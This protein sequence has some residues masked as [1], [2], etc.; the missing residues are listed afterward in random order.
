MKRFVSLWLT[1]W[2]LDRLRRT[3]LA[4]QNQPIC[5]A[6][7]K[8][9]QAFVLTEIVANGLRIAAANTLAAKAGVTPGMMFTDACARLPGLQSEEID[10]KHD[11]H[12]LHRLGLWMTRWT[13]LAALDGLDGVMLDVSGCAHLFGGEAELL[14]DMSNRLSAV[15]ISHRLGLADTPGAAW[16]A[17]RH[18]PMNTIIPPNAQKH[19]L[20]SLPVESLRLSDD[21]VRLLRRFGL[22]RVGQLY[23]VDRKSL[24]R[25]FQSRETAD[26]VV[27]RLDQALGLTLEPIHPLSPPPEYRARLSCPEPLLHT[28]G[29]RAGLETLLIDV[30]AQLT[31]HGKGAREFVFTA[32]KADGG[33]SQVKISASR[34]VRAPDHAMRLFRD[35]LET[36]DP[37]FGLDLLSLEARRTSA[38]EIAAPRFSHLQA[39][40]RQTGDMTALSA[41]VDRIM[42]RLGEDAVTV[43]TPQASHIPERAVEVFAFEGDTPDWSQDEAAITAPRPLRL[44]DR[45]EPV[46]V[47]AETPDGPPR[48]FVWRKVTRNVARAEGPERISPEWWRL[49]SHHTRPRARDYYRVEDVQGRRF[50]LYRDGLYEDDKGDKPVWYMQGLFA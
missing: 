4:L 30:C 47:L 1:N 46:S 28:D 33:L 3:R 24:A 17:A 44:L 40:T 11:A 19:T 6:P 18:A 34:P 10:R 43:H 37:G 39:E 50:W 25:R 14:A 48:R 31:A 32:Y 27:R 35:K 15:G 26:A 7:A 8:P 21:T 23:G 13:P 2:P 38:M 49:D 9:R 45:P 5:A 41:L 36:I 12:A 22:T 29:V 20:G 16:A 42:A